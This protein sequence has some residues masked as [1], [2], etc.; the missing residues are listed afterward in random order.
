[1]GSAL[2]QAELPP[3]TIH[4]VSQGCRSIVRSS[5]ISLMRDVSK[6]SHGPNVKQCSVAVQLAP[7]R[8][9]R[10]VQCSAVQCSAVQCSGDAGPPGLVCLYVLTRAAAVRHTCTVRWCGGTGGQVTS[11]A[12]PTLRSRGDQTNG[13]LKVVSHPQIQR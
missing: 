7:R 12:L 5:I 2:F 8:A 1:M 9:R 3:Q 10:A 4:R 6:L 11:R 13:S